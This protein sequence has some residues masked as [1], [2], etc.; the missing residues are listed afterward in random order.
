MKGI[1]HRWRTPESSEFSVLLTC[2]TK[3]STTRHHPTTSSTEQKFPCLPPIMKHQDVIQL[4]L[5][6]TPASSFIS[7][8]SPSMMN[9]PVEF[10]LDQY[11]TYRWE[12]TKFALNPPKDPPLLLLMIQL[13]F[14]L[15]HLHQLF[16]QAVLPFTQ[17]RL[18][19]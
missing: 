13:I 3:G 16:G 9:S 6:Q 8:V 15:Q 5:P 14:Q 11:H 18:S 4:I 19:I 12:W 1:Q 2:N 17:S 7:R 10:E